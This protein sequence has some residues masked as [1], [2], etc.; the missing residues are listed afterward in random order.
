MEGQF[1]TDFEKTESGASLSIPLPCSD[2]KKGGH[3][4]MDG[5]PCKVME[6]TTSKTGKHGHAKANITG[7]DIFNGKKLVD[8]CPVSHNK[9]MPHVNRL[10]FQLLGVDDEGYVTLLDKVGN[11]RQDLKLSEEED[12]LD[13]SK[14][15]K[16]GLETGRQM[17][18][19]VLSA[20][21][22]EKI[23]EAKEA[24]HQD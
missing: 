5:R 13:V 18:V 21:G 10:E 7:I 17:V 11:V 20:M 3:I 8:V 14:R 12:D 16:D 24:L 23:E 15:I 6:I 1:E 9:E 22:I 2:V 19:T 4:L